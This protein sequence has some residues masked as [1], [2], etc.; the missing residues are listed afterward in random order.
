[1][2]PLVVV[3]DPDGPA[4]R[5][6]AA[7][8]PWLDAGWHVAARWT[9]PRPGER[10]LCTGAIESPDDARRALL[11][12]VAG[13]GLVVAATADRAIVDQFLDELRRLGPVEHVTPGARLRARL[14]AEQRRLLGLL[15]EGLTL[16]EAA[17]QLGLSRRTADRRLAAARRVLGVSTTAEAIVASRT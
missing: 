3:D 17:A 2:R 4:A 7:L 14:D 13:A 16:G 15:A 10:L 5:L 8:V 12:A 1:M 9:A 6:D 11:A